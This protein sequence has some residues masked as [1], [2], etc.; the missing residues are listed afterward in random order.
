MKGFKMKIIKT[1]LLL[2]LILGGEAITHAETQISGNAVTD[3]S[4]TIS[5]LVSISTL[6]ATG[7]TVSTIIAGGGSA[8]T[9]SYSFSGDTNTGMWSNLADDLNFSTG[10]STRAVITSTGRVGI[11]TASPAALL[12]LTNSSDAGVRAET[13]GSGGA[14]FL[15]MRNP[16]I[17]HEIGIE[18]ESDAGGGRYPGAA[19]SLN[20]YVSGSYPLTFSINN[21]IVLN[22]SSAGEITQPLQP[23]FLVTNSAGATDVTGDGTV[24]TLPWPTE[25]YDQGSDFSSNTFTAPVSG[26]YSLTATFEFED[27]LVT[28]TVREIVIVTSNREYRFI[29]WESLAQA[30]Q[31]MHVCAIADMD[32]NDTA[33]VTARVIGSTKTVDILASS[34]HNFFSGS[35]IN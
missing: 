15:Q 21:A 29:F 9:P 24:Y 19:S 16:A 22:S 1:Y 2:V 31:S 32:A 33:T 34:I 8:T 7:I 14:G 17:F 11:G 23:S 4:F 30:G 20:L 35:L 10:G 25:V 13:I 3:S 18:T 6:T 27:I 26:R 28:H 5:G 12:H